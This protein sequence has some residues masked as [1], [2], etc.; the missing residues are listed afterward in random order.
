[1]N[2]GRYV[3]L[4]EFVNVRQY[5]DAMANRAILRAA[6]G[7]Y[8]GKI[9]R[10]VRRLRPAVLAAYELPMGLLGF[11]G[12]GWLFAGFPFTASILLLG[13][14][15]F[16][17]AVIPAAF[18]PY[19]TGPLRNHQ[20]FSF[21]MNG[22]R[23]AALA[24][25]LNFLWFQEERGTAWDKYI[26]RGLDLTEGIGAV[27]GVNTN[28]LFPDQVYLITRHT[29]QPTTYEAV[30]IWRERKFDRQAPGQGNIIIR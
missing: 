20:P 17:W 7:A 18:T 12:V 25:P 22:T 21:P 6:P 3:P 16:T 28:L 27:V 30:V 1:M 11:P 2:D 9:P 23:A 14:P 10:R 13:G 19:G 5:L 26:S 4:P 8:T 29:E 15:A 24:I